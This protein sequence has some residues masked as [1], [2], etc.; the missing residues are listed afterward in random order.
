MGIIGVLNK[1]RADLAQQP[2]AQTQ[3]QP[4]SFTNA[5]PSF[6]SQQSQPSYS[7]PGSAGNGMSNV[8][9][10]TMGQAAQTSS[11]PMN[12]TRDQYRDKWMGSG[13]MTYQGMQDWLGQNGGTMLSGNGVVRTPFGDTLDMGYNA[14]GAQAGEGLI[15]PFWTRVDDSS[16][17]GSPGGMQS[18]G[19]SNFNPNMYS[20]SNPSM[21]TQPFGS[22]MQSPMIGQW[23]SGQ[24][25]SMMNSAAP[26]NMNMQG[27]DSSQADISSFLGQ[28]PQRK[29]FAQ[30]GMM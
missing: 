27:S 19:P 11:N 28:A 4:S 18:A 26:S 30:Q 2:Q 17:G 12:L 16:G 20:G 23:G 29:L 1:Q 22:T 24:P 3:Q 14:R 15:K 7:N 9:P 21:Q 25:S 8:G 5:A 6:Q 13:P 10:S